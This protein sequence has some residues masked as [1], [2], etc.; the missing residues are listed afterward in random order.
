MITLEGP[1]LPARSGRTRHL[2]VLLHGYG[3]DGRDLID[4][5][6]LWAAMLPDAA[7]VA[8]HAPQ[9]CGEAPVGRQWFSLASRDPDALRRGARAAAPS[10]DAFLDAERDRNGLRDADVALVGFSQGA[11][12]ALHVG[13]RRQAAPAAVVG[14]SGRL[15]EPPLAG[16]GRPPV[17]LIHGALDDVVEPDALLAAVQALTAADVPCTWHLASKLGHEIDAD[18]AGRAAAFLAAAFGA[19]DTS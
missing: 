15:V 1:R 18:V 8:P 14:L 4:L 19:A 13:L 10:L 12:M 11:M 16:I 7:F 6:S 17:L 5:G 3:A 2:V 9:P